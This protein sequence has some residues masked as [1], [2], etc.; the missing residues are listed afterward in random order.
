MTNQ[1]KKVDLRK[2]SEAQAAADRLREEIARLYSKAEKMTTTLKLVPTI[3]G[4]GRGIESAIEGIG[5]LVDQ[6][7]EKQN[8][9][10][11]LRCKIEDAISMVPDGRLRLL[12]E[13]KYI[14]GL[15]WERIAEKMGFDDVRWIYRLHRK[16]LSG[17]TIESHA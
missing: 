17:L 9:A 14:D 3:G 2:Y 6:L 7:S 4:G 1:E 15:T 13:Y 16:A 10:N 8:E 12:L 5:E 11:Q